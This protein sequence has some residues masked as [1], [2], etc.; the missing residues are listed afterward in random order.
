M[1]SNVTPD[2]HDELHHDS[3]LDSEIAQ[4]TIRW[5]TDEAL[6]L[7]LKFA[8]HDLADLHLAVLSVSGA[9]LLRS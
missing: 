2:D 1:R 9:L 3:L 7:S 6:R 8:P 4:P 5:H